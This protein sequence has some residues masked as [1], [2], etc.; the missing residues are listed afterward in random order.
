[1]DY[2]RREGAQSHSTISHCGYFLYCG[3][4]IFL[5]P[6]PLPLIANPL[7]FQPQEHTICH[8]LLFQAIPS[9]FPALWS[10][11]IPLDDDQL[12][13]HEED[14]DDE[15]EE[16]SV[17]KAAAMHIGIASRLLGPQLFPILLPYLSHLTHPQFAIRHATLTLLTYSLDHSFT[18][19]SAV[20]LLQSVEP[21]HGP[22]ISMN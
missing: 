12:L 21:F 7:C 16:W 17:N 3:N 5:P 22:L 13:E 8:Q 10:A 4:A 19:P 15:D 1:M 11:L 9:L 20:P 14:N 18:S 6:S 2:T